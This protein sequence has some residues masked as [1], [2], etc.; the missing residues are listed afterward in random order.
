[1][2]RT[3]K[4]HKRQLLLATALQLFSQHG[5]EQVSTAQIAHQAGVAS[6]SLFFHFHSKHALIHSLFE[7]VL[8]QLQQA[9]TTPAPTCCV[10]E[11]FIDHYTQ[12]ANYWLTHPI[13]LGFIKHYYFSPIA[14]P[15][16]K[17]SLQTTCTGRLVACLS[18]NPHHVHLPTSMIQSVLFGGL[19]LLSQDHRAS[20][21]TRHGQLCRLAEIYWTGFS[22]PDPL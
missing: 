9:L 14:L 19:M 6:G 10:Q 5:L 3:G 12:V 22:Q 13:E 17:T 7:H 20:S 8:Q 1:M 11:K 2:T 15:R 4:E 16:H 18:A 21:P